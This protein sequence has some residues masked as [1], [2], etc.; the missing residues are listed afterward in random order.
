MKHLLIALLVL[1]PGLALA[2][3]GYGYP[4]D[5]PWAQMRPAPSGGHVLT[6]EVSDDADGW[7][8]LAQRGE[9][10]RTGYLDP[11]ALMETPLSAAQWAPGEWLQI[12]TTWIAAG[13]SRTS[14]HTYERPFVVWLP[15]LHR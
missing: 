3:D 7:R 14:C 9:V 5:R 12:C 1:L 8:V 4:A 13:I 15:L 6:W 10:W 11:G 2:S